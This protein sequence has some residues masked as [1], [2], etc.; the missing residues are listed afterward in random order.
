MAH[1]ENLD[2]HKSMLLAEAEGDGDT[3]GLDVR[4][5]RTCPDVTCRALSR[6][7][8]LWRA[9]S[10]LISFQAM[11]ALLLANATAANFG[12]LRF[13]HRQQLCRE[14]HARRLDGGR[15]E[16]SQTRGATQLQPC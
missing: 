13:G 16:I 9:M 14:I 7:V 8:S 10:G 2:K 12:G 5:Y 6:Q 4:R 3:G 1:K 15:V 11:R